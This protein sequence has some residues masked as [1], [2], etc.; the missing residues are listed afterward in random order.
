MQKYSAFSYK[1]GNS[2]FHKMPAWLKILLIPA[3]NIL[4]F[5]LH[6]LVS[7]GF[8]ILQ[9]IIACCLGF[10]IREQFADLKPVIFYAVILYGI[11]F[12]N[13]T[14]KDLTIAFQLIKL[15][16]VM[17]S[18]SI[19]FKTSTSLEIRDGVGAIEGTVRKVLHLKNKNTLT[20]TISLFVC[21]IPLV[22]KIWEQSKLV[23]KARGGKKGIRMYLKLLPVLFSVGM[24]NAWN[25]ARALTVREG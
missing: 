23:W 6:P 24:K 16:A 9:F 8:V 3:L 17:Q 5:N 10:S 7:V 18:A 22:Y 15:F 19:V 20:N 1:S 25:S 11:S 13:G 4:V 14:Y 12:I 2:L 21:F